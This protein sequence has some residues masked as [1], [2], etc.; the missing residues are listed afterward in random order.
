MPDQGSFRVTRTERTVKR[1]AIAFAIAAWMMT[2]VAL[3]A[4]A[5]KR[6]FDPSAKALLSKA[7]AASDIEAKDSPAFRLEA[8]IRVLLGDGRTENG[9]LLWIWTPVG[10]WHNELTLSEYR[11]I[12]ISGGNQI[13]MKSTE[14]SIPYPAFL[15]DRAVHLSDWLRQARGR[16]FSHPETSAET[17]ETCVDSRGESKT[18]DP[19]R[20]CFDSLSGQLASVTDRGWNVT[21]RYLDYAP[22]G[23]KSFPRKIQVLRSDQSVFVEVRVVRLVQEKKPDLRLFLPVQ[24]ATEIPVGKACGHVEA[25]KL[26]KMVQPVFPREAMNEGITGVVKLYADI[27]ADGIPRGMWPVNS[28]TPILAQAAIDAVRQ[29]RYTPRTCKAS[30]AKLRQIQIITILFSSP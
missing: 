10:W 27:G 12:E 2:G 29:W 14:K 16:K 28:P 22:F 6:A 11:S 30:G 1:A 26:Q 7:L 3:A 4:R 8:R 13:W 23:K 24:G 15:E 5:H 18:S 9:K 19:L 21:Y 20:Y 25:A 17:G